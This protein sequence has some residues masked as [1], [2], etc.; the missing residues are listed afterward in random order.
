MFKKVVLAV[1]SVLAV[2]GVGFATSASNNA[3]GAL[4]EGETS[5]SLV[6]SSEAPTSTSSDITSS[7][8][9]TSSSEA[10]IYSATIS[11]SV[12]YIDDDGKTIADENFTHG[13]VVFS[14]DGGSAGDKVVAVVQGNP[15]MEVE[16]NN[17]SLYRYLISDFKVNGVSVSPVDSSSGEYDFTL[18]DG[19]NTVLVTFSGKSKISVIDLA[20]LNWK[21]LLTVDNLLK[22]ITVIALLIISSGFF[23]TLIKNKKITSTTASEFSKS[24]TEVMQSVAKLVISDVMKN[25]VAPIIE[26]Q[27]EQTKEAAEST[28]AL[29]RIALYSLSGT[30]EDKLAAIKELQN[31]KGTDQNLANKITEIVNASI[32]KSDDEKAAKEKAISDAKEAVSNLEGTE[33]ASSSK[34]DDSTTSDY[35]KL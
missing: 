7:Q 18:V 15:E 11:Y 23:I 26:K 6:A 17:I 28:E 33:E 8:S 29:M 20:S 35:G 1:A 32:K 5:S 3:I 19:A 13:D 21:T 22:F 25:T 9:T 12:C 24:G 14:I 30:S 2:V 10:P 4:A 27:S 34:D 16:G 31:Y